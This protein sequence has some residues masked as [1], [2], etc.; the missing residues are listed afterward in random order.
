MGN[1]TIKELYLLAK[2]F[3]SYQI[4]VIT[5]SGKTMVL[6]VEDTT[7]ILQLKNM[8]EEKENIK[9]HEQRIFYCGK[10][11]ENPHTMSFYNL[12]QHN[13]L[14]LLIRLLG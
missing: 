1:K 2:S 11:L 12:T 6:E 3:F 8:I 10:Q 13:T 4:Y 9:T 5:L 7:T 14:H